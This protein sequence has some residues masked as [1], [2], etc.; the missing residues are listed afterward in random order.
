VQRRVSHD[1]LTAI[2]LPSASATECVR[3][4]VSLGWMAS[5]WTEHECLMTK[6]PF[7]LVVPLKPELASEEVR[8]IVDQAGI[9]PI[10]FVDALEK[11]RTARLTNY[12]DSSFD[13]NSKA[14]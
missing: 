10:A 14:G 12:V 5:S 7:S 2:P 11:I 3:V 8:A 6:G 1:R 4:L 9:S 13:P